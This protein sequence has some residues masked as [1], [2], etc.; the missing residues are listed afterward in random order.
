MTTD[1]FVFLNFDNQIPSIN[2]LL[3]FIK[4]AFISKQ[5]IIN[6][7]KIFV[8][9]FTV[10]FLSMPFDIFSIKKK[11]TQHSQRILGEYM[12]IDE[13]KENILITFLFTYQITEKFCFNSKILICDKFL[14]QT[15]TRQSHQQYLTLEK[16]YE[17]AHRKERMMVKCCIP[18][19]IIFT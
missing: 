3:Q 9:H 6:K 13:N 16:R 8:L 12:V 2:K 10:F 4:K 7:R 18:C 1:F 15:Q 11:G 14:S 17:A 19:I 5:A